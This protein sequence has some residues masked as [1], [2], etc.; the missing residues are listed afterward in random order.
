MVLVFA[1]LSF[2]IAGVSAAENIRYYY[3]QQ[4]RLVRVEYSSGTVIT[5]A[6]DSAGNRLGKTVKTTPALPF[7][8]LLL[9]SEA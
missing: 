1:L 6:Y 2:S 9:L 5:Y 8:H 3:D 7:L 4:S